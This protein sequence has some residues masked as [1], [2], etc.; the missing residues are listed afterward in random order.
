M[1]HDTTESSLMVATRSKL[2]PP[3]ESSELSFGSM[4]LGMDLDIPSENTDA[5]ELD[6]W[7]E[8][9]SVSICAVGIIYRGS[10]AGTMHSCHCTLL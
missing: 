10:N 5:S 6:Q 8:E 2:L 3:T 7:E 9:S 4:D 1:A